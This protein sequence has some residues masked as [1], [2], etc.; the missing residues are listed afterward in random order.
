MPIFSY[1]DEKIILE[2]T[3]DV[4]RPKTSDHD[5][6]FLQKTINP[7]T[8][9]PVW[10]AMGWRGAGTVAATYALLR[11]WKEIGIL[12]GSHPFGILIGMNDK[13]GWQQ[14][15][16]VRIYPEPKCYKKIFH[17]VVWRRISK[18]ISDASVSMILGKP[19]EQSASPDRR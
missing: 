18:A 8:G 15:H 10:V 13:D 19:T 17:P 16:I 11:W 2:S 12:Y 6:G 9:F 5:I 4:Y 14:S 3:K 7:V 1:R